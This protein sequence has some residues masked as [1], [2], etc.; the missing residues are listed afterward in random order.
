MR[1]NNKSRGQQMIE[2]TIIFI[3]SLIM[4]FLIAKEAERRR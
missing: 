4:W 2:F 1:K 3:G